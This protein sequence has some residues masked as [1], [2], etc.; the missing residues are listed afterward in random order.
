MPSIPHRLQPGNRG[1]GRLPA[2]PRTPPVPA[3]RAVVDCGVY[4]DGVRQRDSSDFRQALHQVRQSGE[5]FVWLGLHHPDERQMNDVAEAFGLHPLM[6]EDAVHAHQRPKLET[7]DDMIFL[8]L[9]TISYIDH[10][11]LEVAN[12]IVETGEIMI[13]AGSDFV[14]TVRH[15]DHTHLAGVRQR[16]EHRTDQLRLGPAAVVHAVADR[17]VDSYLAVVSDMESDVDEIEERVFSAKH[18]DVDIDV[19]YLFK[20]EVLE[21]QRAVDPL[22]LP[23]ARL[24]GNKSTLDAAPVRF[25]SQTVSAN[26]K[27]IRRHFRDVADH[28]THAT[29]LIA[30]YDERLTTLLNAAATKVSIQQNTDMRKISSWAAI[31]AVPTAIAGIYGM[32]FDHM[33]ELHWTYSYPVLL[34][35]MVCI[36]SA[37]W[38]TLRRNHWL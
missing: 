11:S 3:A 38:R 24:S 19:V 33:P 22:G 25:E 15:G 32:N 16:L 26:S 29:D 2:A 20:R 8:V 28:L 7:Y 10:E 18:N 6:V 14:I 23:L 9:R 13:L 5:G 21:L 4:V 36:C 12:D 27:E 17:V 35:I 30:E 34:L 1:S 37:L 31:A